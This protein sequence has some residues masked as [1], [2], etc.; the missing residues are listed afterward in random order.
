[1]HSLPLV[2]GLMPI[3]PSLELAAIFGMLTLGVF[4]LE[5]RGYRLNKLFQAVSAFAIF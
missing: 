1:M 2:D 5:Q 3:Q 4:W